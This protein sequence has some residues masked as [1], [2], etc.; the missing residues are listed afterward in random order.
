MAWSKRYCTSLQLT[1][2]AISFLDKNKKDSRSN[3]ISKLIRKHDCNKDNLI[4]TQSQYHKGKGGRWQIFPY[5]TK[6]TGV[7][8]PDKENI[9]K[10]SKELK[11]SLSDYVE[12]VILCTDT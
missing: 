5:K 7:Y 4:P 9:L 1:E 10:K 3:Y 2:E 6:T 12:W 11:I 8:L